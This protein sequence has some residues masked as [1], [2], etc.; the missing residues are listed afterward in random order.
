MADRKTSPPASLSPLLDG[1]DLRTAF[2]RRKDANDYQ[3]V[4][5]DDEGDLIEAGWSLHKR[6]QSHVWL[7][8][9]KSPDS[10]LEDRVWCLFYRMGYP[11]LS[12]SKFRIEYRNND[13]TTGH[14]RIDVFAADDETAVVV[15]CRAREVR[16]RRSF[17]KDIEDIE[18]AQ[19]KVSQSI[20]S[21]LGKGANPKIIWIVATSN[22]IW[23]ERDVERCEASN[24]RIITENELQYF[25]AF[26]AHI[27]TAGR[28]QFLAEFLEG[29]EIPNLTNVRVPAARGRFGSH[30]YYS[31]VVSARH[32][33]K[34]AFVNHQALNHP[35]G[36]PAYQRMINKKRIN[37]IG[38][39]ISTGR[40][41]SPPTFLSILLSLCRFDLISNK[42]NADQNI[43]F[44]WLYLPSNYKSAWIIDGQHRLYGFSNI[45]DRYLDTSLF[46]LA[47]E[48]MDTKT[49]ADLFITINHEQRSVSKSL[50]VTLQAD[51]K[52]G[53]GDPKE[54]ISALG[55]AL[56][57][58]INSDNA[59]PFFRRFEIP[60]VSPTQ[61]QNLTIAEAVKGLIRSNLL[62]RV[63]PKKSKVAGFLSGQTD[64]ETLVRA[65]KIVNGY[66]RSIMDANPTRWERGR[67][68]YICVNPGVRAHFQLI[69][70]ALQYAADNG[71]VDPTTEAPEKVVVYLVSFI[72]PILTLVSSGSDSLIEAKFSRKFGDG[73]VA[74]YFYN[75]CDVITKKH[76]D[77]EVRN[78][79]NT[80]IARLTLV[81]S[82]QMTMWATCKIASVRLLLIL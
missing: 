34:I 4:G 72:E 18:G 82:R 75:L 20:R 79:R 44:G 56:I 38:L 53:S 39:F 40:L 52:I 58:S 62:G 19:R 78:T 55:S 22:I 42:D 35:D 66:F 54:A 10:M 77:L 50:L 11:R 57:R 13:G 14:K 45:P 68:A 73:G 27:G 37:D 36:R 80:K 65:R 63:L 31:F 8:K 25:E 23:A 15:D 32:L 21:H 60:G 26:V 67:A 69:Q 74:E 76:K 29:Q 61:S 71:I 16:G 5:T 47:F 6:M 33:L 12:G 59:S 2:R 48:K 51:L 9:P 64:A 7:K 81:C 49:E 41:F 28:Y 30:T 46:V 43:K 24:I 1:D 70:E 17:Q 3:K